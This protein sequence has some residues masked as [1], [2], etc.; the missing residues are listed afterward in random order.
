MIPVDHPSRS[1]LERII[2]SV[3]D[4]DQRAMAEASRRQVRLTKPAGSLGRLERLA[5]QVAGV[6][7]QT[8]PRLE[9]KAIV[10]MAGDHGVSA[11]GVSAYPASVTAQMVR[12]FAHDGAAINVL[13]RRAHARVVVVDVGVAQD[14]P[15][16]LQ[17]VHRKVARGTANLA[18]GRAMMEKQALAAIQVGLDVVE[19][20]AQ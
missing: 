1:A 15:P 17:I 13:A 9:H 11:E 8:R 10:V 14:F 5:A 6:T 3:Q 20:E 2:N 4:L 16:D 12:N 19:Q 18:I 7:G